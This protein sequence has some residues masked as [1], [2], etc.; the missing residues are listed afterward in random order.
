MVG[1]TA[2][3]WI[4]KSARGATKERSHSRREAPL[5]HR[6]PPGAPL[7][8]SPSPLS[9]TTFRSERDS[10]SDADTMLNS[11]SYEKMKNLFPEFGI[12]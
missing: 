11:M 6:L 3:K 9:S 4:L 12:L 5:K 10:D 2:Q 1:R 8:R 7:R